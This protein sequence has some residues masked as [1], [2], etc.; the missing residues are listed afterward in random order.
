MFF[1]NSR[2]VFALLACS[3]VVIFL[4]FYEAILSVHLLDTY[5]LGA[6]YNGYIFAVP[7]LTYCLSTPFVSELTDRVSSKRHFIL[8]ALLLCFVSLLLAGPSPTLGL[9][10]SLWLLVFGLGMNGIASGFAF[11]PIYPEIMEAVMEHEGIEEETDELCDKVSGIYGT[12]YSLGSIIAPVFGGFLGERLGYRAT[13]D[14]VAFTTLAFVF[15]YFLINTGM[16]KKKSSK[17]EQSLQY[18]NKIEAEFSP[19]EKL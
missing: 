2:C 18:L 15:L 16:T 7:C 8:L 11:I 17:V 19:E 1:N 4:D 9:G 10:D 6:D 5:K 13:C 14:I 12:F 3:M